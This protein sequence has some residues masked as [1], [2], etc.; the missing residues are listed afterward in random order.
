MKHFSWRC[1]LLTSF[2]YPPQS[3]GSSPVLTLGTLKLHVA[4][5]RDEKRQYF[6]VNKLM[7]AASFVFFTFDTTS[8]LTLFKSEPFCSW[9][10]RHLMFVVSEMNYYYINRKHSLG[11]RGRLWFDNQSS[12]E[13]RLL[14]S[15][16]TSVQT[17]KKNICNKETM[18]KIKSRIGSFDAEQ[19]PIKVQGNTFYF[20]GLTGIKVQHVKYSESRQ[21]SQS[22]IPFF[23]LRDT[24]R[25]TLKP[26][27]LHCW[28]GRERRKGWNVR[29]GPV[30]QAGAADDYNRTVPPVWVWV[31]G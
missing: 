30:H 24:F 3:K 2:I 22:N 13:T 20:Q 17:G 8:D 5:V 16:S 10:F 29:S 9:C 4:T 18:Q 28:C 1:I 12:N 31:K 25:L 19:R 6:P 21:S 27:I 7:N 23:S 11:G 26:P 15:D 14:R